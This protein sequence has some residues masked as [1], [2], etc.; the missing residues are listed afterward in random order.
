MCLDVTVWQLV[1]TCFLFFLA[2]LTPLGPYCR[3]EHDG[4]CV[5]VSSVA[6]VSYILPLGEMITLE[7]P[8]TVRTSRDAT[9]HFLG[10]YAE[11]LCRDHRVDDSVETL[12]PGA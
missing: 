5:I 12:G 11:D 4:L 6:T 2:L 7:D 9:G 8:G 3:A 10:A 1:S